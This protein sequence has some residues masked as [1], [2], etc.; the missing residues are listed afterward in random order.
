MQITG[1]ITWI[2]EVQSGEG[3]NGT[4]N[5][6]SAV[7]T[8]QEGQYPQS[9]SFEVFN[10]KVAVVMDELCT[11]H[12]QTK[13]NEYNGRHYTNINAWKKEGGAAQPAQAPKPAGATLPAQKPAPIAT[14]ALAA[15]DSGLPF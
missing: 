4:W 14:P 3:K 7:I 13:A 1:K 9:L 2:S 11:I 5:K 12:F 6:F 10:D 15:D 8:E